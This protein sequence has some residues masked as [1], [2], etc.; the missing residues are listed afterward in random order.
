MKA[1]LFDVDGVITN[2][3][4]KKSNPEIIYK[5]HLLLK[6]GDIVG[7]NTG[8]SI[9]FISQEVLIPLENI[10][11]EKK[12]L[13]NIYS[14][15]EKGGVWAKYEDQVLNLSI[16]ESLRPPPELENK[17]KSLIK[18]YYSNTTFLDKSKKTMIST[19]LKKGIN[20]SKFTEDQNKLV[21]ILEKIL[22]E[23]KLYDFSLEPT[24]IATDIQHKKAGKDL[25][26]E[27][28]LELIKGMHEPEEFE[29]FG[30]SPGDLEMHLYLKRNGHKSKFIYVGKKEIETKEDIILSTQK[31]DLGT[32]EYLNKTI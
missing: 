26:V 6:N 5:I 29:T 11:N 12:L 32:I 24:L 23:M 2:P 16:D 27:R 10:V 28:F 3:E 8:R 17:V 20:L 25:G 18:D 9:D 15:G 21:K 7:L 13:D 31:Y 14:V 30:D 19:E 22:K 4:L 1:W